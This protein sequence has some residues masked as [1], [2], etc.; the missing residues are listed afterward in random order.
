MTTITLN[1]TPQ[2]GNDFFNNTGITEDGG[3][4]ILDVMANDL[5]GK[6]KT[7]FSLDDGSATTDLLIRDAVGADNFSKFGSL[8]E[9]TSDNKVAYTM[10][11]ESKA[12]FQSLA[13]GDV[14]VDTFTYAIRMG[15]GTLSWATTTVE[16]K[17]VNDIPVITS[18]TQ[19]GAVTED[20]TLVASGQVTSTD[21]DNGATAAYSGNASSNYG[22][23]VINATTGEW[24]YTLDNNVAQPLNADQTITETY[25]VTVTDDKGAKVT[26]DVSITITGANEAPPVVVVATPVTPVNA[27]VEWVVNLGQYRDGGTITGFDN[28]DMLNPAGNL[29]YVGFEEINA[30]T[31]VSF[32]YKV[33][34]GDIGTVEITLVGYTD[35]TDA[36]V[37]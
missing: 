7:L 16:I 15:N 12:V 8:I 23:F 18:M 32:D 14:A 1:N 11:S 17:G 13:A 25:T 27:V 26:Q 4:F 37:I 5:G 9:I 34:K 3:S 33:G 10:T 6:A 30:D 29:D 19:T 36:Q 21:V 20:G 22:S 35:F 31:V 24:T 28:N 2:A